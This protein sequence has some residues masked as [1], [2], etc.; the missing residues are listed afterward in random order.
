M[1]AG[2]NPTTLQYEAHK[3]PLYQCFFCLF[4]LAMDRTSS[5]AKALMKIAIKKVVDVA[6][7]YLHAD[8]Q[9]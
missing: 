3:L 5:R 1:I 6:T 8:A 9:F 2:F 4:P 7:M